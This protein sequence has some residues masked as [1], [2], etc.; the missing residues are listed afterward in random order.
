ME[1]IPLPPPCGQCGRSVGLWEPILVGPA[2]EEAT[3]WLALSERWDRLPEQILHHV[4]P[5]RDDPRSSR[6]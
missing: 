6:G 5:E 2:Y 1:R 3:T 4:C